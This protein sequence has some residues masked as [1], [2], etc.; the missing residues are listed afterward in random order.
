[1][2][3]SALYTAVWNMTGEPALTLPVSQSKAGLPLAVQ[4]VGPPAGE[5]VLLR[6]A[7]QLEE[8]SHWA[9][10]QVDHVH[11]RDRRPTTPVSVPYSDVDHHGLNARM[12]GCMHSGMPA[13]RR[14]EGSDANPPPAKVQMSVYL[15][16]SL[17]R[18]VKHKAIDDGISLSHLVE[19]ALTEYLQAHGEA[20]G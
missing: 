13:S 11:G 4:L 15:P 8:A 18:R 1:M 10:R 5:D 16:P 2:T 20:A 17:I 9:R 19:Q 6:L 7:A 12:P 3:S 14:T